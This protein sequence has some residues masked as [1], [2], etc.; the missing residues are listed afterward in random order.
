MASAFAHALLA[1]T[2]GKAFRAK[3]A[4]RKFWLLGIACSVLPDADVIM[5]RLGVPY[6]HVM[7]HRGFSHSLVFALLLGIL[8]TL[9]FYRKIKLMTREGITLVLFFFLCT[10][11]HALLDAMTTGGLGVAVFAPF[12]NDRYFLPWRPIKVSPIGLAEF[13][14]EWGLRVL[15]SEF[16]WVFLPCLLFMLLISVMKRTKKQEV[17]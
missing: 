17:H 6:E 8:I 7:G 14:G 3:Y 16:I 2:I 5:F 15:K 4:S 9:V 13:F 10:A 11:S 1:V 12:D